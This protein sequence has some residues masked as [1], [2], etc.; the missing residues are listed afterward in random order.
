MVEGQGEVR[1]LVSLHCARIESM[2][3][4]QDVA[5]WITLHSDVS[6]S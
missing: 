6:N 4:G 3:T 5:K 1:R 2:E